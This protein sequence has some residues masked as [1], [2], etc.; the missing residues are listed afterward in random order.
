[1]ELIKELPDVFEEFAE[2][3]QQSFLGIKEL[4]DKGVPIVGTF[5]T[6]FHRKSRWQWEQLQ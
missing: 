2:Q 4:K 5:C 1:M 6:Y 3:R